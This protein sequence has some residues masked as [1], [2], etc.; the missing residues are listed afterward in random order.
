MTNLCLA[1]LY[2]IQINSFEY[3]IMLLYI[4]ESFI[5]FILYNHNVKES[6]IIDSQQ[7]R[8]TVV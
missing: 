8:V 5:M 4:N 2:Y 1:T 7:Q 6:F 3:N